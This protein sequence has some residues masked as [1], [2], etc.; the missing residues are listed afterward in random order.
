[1]LKLGVTKQVPPTFIYNHVLHN[2]IMYSTWIRIM[3]TTNM[4]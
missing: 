1:M 3:D 4:T 2:V